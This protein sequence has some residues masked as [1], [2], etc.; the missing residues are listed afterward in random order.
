MAIRTIRKEGDDILKKKSREV[1][2]VNESINGLMDDMLETL[3]HLDGVGI[4]APQVG[5][6][7][8]IVIIEFEEDLYEL[9]NPVITEREGDQ[10]CNE[11]CLSVPGRCGD[12]VRPY[13]VT[14]E[15]FNRDMEPII[16]EA[17]DFMS[18]VFCHEIDH[19]DGVLFLESASNVQLITSEQLEKRKRDRKR[20]RRA[21]FMR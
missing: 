7:K 2:E 12:I 9:I 3:R 17:E 19:L 21:R 8:R 15:A 14:I 18:S 10:V 6:L 16:V 5:A 4:A 11:A 20:R 13:K 1:K